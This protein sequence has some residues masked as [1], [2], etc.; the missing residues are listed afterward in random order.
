[1]TFIVHHR[2]GNPAAGGAPFAYPIT[3]GEGWAGGYHSVGYEMNEPAK[4]PAP[5][6]PAPAAPTCAVPS[7]HGLSLKSAKAR[8]RSADCSIGPV[9]LAPGASAGKGEVVKQFRTAGTEL[10]AGTPVAVKLGSRQ[11]G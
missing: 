4:P 6:P 10:A 3:M 5:T 9:R 2:A 7:L 8:L 1:M 11:A